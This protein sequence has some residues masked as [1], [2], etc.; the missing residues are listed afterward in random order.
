M[1]M[2]ISEDVKRVRIRELKI[3]LDSCLKGQVKDAV[4]V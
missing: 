1:D 3:R 2:I 4:R